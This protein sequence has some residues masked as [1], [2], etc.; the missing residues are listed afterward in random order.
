VYRY[1]QFGSYDSGAFSG[2]GRF[3]LTLDAQRQWRHKKYDVVGLTAEEEA[4]VIRLTNVAGVEDDLGK[5]PRM[6]PPDPR[7]F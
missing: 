4:R 6:P 3:L 5:L 2:T 1:G 7:E